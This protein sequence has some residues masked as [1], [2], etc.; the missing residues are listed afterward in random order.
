MIPL[1]RIA[2]LVLVF[3]ALLPSAQGQM[4]NR[5][6]VPYAWKTDTSQRVIPLEELQVVLPRRSFPTIDYPAFMAKNEGLKNFYHKEPVIA[7]CIGGR[8]KAYPLNMLTTHEISNDTLAGVP[9]L[10]TYCPLCNASVVYDR[11]IKH[12]GEEH[13]LEFEVSGMLRKSDMVMADKATESWWQQLSGKGL[14]GDYA[15]AEL[16]IIPSQVIT[17]EEFFDRFPEGKILSTHTKY[18]ERYGKNP[19]SS[20]DD[21]D[22]RPMN[23]FFN[24]EH[25]DRRLPPM[26]RVV[27][28]EVNDAFK[29]YPLPTVAEAK[30]L[31]DRFEGV[32]IVLFYRPSAVSVLDKTNI[33]DSRTVGTVTALYP[34]V[35]DTELTFTSSGP[36][37]QDKE[38]GSTWDVTGYCVKGTHQGV[39]LRKHLYGM[40]FAFAWLAFHPE[41]EIYQGP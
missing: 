27:N 25:I 21:K 15:G 8:A 31:H 12:E 29:V 14:V 5:R 13:L 18:R 16:R 22:G 20:Y 30:V 7:V 34:Q 1:L 36:H 4:Q 26:Q 37:F 11:R 17:V 24:H 10:A 28:V 35:G 23:M 9:L 6:G 39:Q 3:T 2:L 40:H 33:R 41:T 38:T 19:Y 32:R